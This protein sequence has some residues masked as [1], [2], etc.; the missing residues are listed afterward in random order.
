MSIPPPT[1]PQSLRELLKDYPEHI[2][3]L[4]DDLSHIAQKT[5]LGIPPFEQAVWMLEDALSE[6][7]VQARAELEAAEASGDTD[8]IEQSKAK[9]LLMARASSKLQWISDEGL[10][11]YFQPNREAFK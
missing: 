6:F 8:A 11:S 9:T 4:Q 10:R 7:V 3:T 1:V 2:Q 5:R